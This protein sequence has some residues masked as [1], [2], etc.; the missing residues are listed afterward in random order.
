MTWASIPRARSQRASQNPSR[1]ASN[2][3]A[4]RV[5]WRPAW[6]ASPRLGR[7]A[8]P[9]LEQAQQRRLISRE[10]LERVARDPGDDAGD[11]PTRSA[12]FDDSDQGAVLVQ[13]D[14]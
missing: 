3:T 14:G 6:V 2:A 13:S 7:L 12:H 10:L 8:P 1:P 4:M 11:E 9:A 5:I